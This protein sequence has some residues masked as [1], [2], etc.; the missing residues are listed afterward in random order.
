MRT[1]AIPL[2]NWSR[3]LLLVFTAAGLAMFCWP[4]LLTGSQNTQHHL[5]APY[6]FM[7]VIPMLV[8]LVLAQLSEGGL[9]SKAL[10]ILGVLAAVNAALRPVGAGVGGV[11]LVFFLLVLGG[12]V[13]G[14][15]FGFVLGS[16]SLFASALLTAGVGPW[17]PFQMICAAWIGMGAG[18]LPERLGSHL[19]R[20]VPEMVMLASYGVVASYLYGLL[21]NL[22]FWP[23]VTADTMA[24]SS[25]AYNSAAGL[26]D[27]L[28]NFVRF[29]LIT[30]TASWDTVRAITTAA[31]VTAVG[32]GV[33]F[34]LRR[35]SRRANFRPLT[36]FV[37]SHSSASVDVRKIAGT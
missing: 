18:L 1:T 35:A 3:L 32:P 34:V 24:N 2:G 21:M 36:L 10:A 5:D 13:F 26:G 12:R 37:D 16:M 17:L 6:F 23:F 25:L 33:L 15:G 28:T 7:L 31:L 4:L 19:I 29:T 11:E 9:D 20:G 22:W 14:A 8:L 30:S 27:N